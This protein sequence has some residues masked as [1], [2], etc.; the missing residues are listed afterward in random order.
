MKCPRD[1][2]T[3]QHVEIMGVELDKCHKCDGIWFDRGELEHL[4]DAKIEGIEEV[5]EK[6]YGDPEFEEGA[7]KGYMHCPRCD[8]GR[9]N[10]F[11]YTYVNPVHVD[12]CGKC[13]GIWLDDGELDAIIGEKKSVDEIDQPKKLKGFLKV[14]GGLIKR[15]GQ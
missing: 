4:R 5:I 12:R 10:R 13:M 2:T 7:P 6:K 8:D 11:L 15:R 3:L 9:L 1:G 14:M